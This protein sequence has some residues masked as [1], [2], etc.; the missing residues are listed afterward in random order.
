MAAPKSV[1]VAN[2]SLTFTQQM[3]AERDRIKARIATTNARIKKV[4]E[5]LNGLSNEVK[6]LENSL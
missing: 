4:V 2:V 6:E 3:E 1:Q 5:Q